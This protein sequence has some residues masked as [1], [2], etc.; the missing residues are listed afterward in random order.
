MPSELVAPAMFVPIA[1]NKPPPKAT[2]FQFELGKVRC[3][4]VI[5]SGLLSAMVLEDEVEIAT[6]NPFPYAKDSQFDESG[7]VR[8]GKS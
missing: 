7:R 6:N 4:H 1:T 8:D 2:A 5:P 3:V